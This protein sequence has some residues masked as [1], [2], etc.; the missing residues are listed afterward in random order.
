MAKAFSLHRK[1]I[2]H[3]DSMSEFLM[4]SGVSALAKHIKA[5]EFQ[6]IT[7]DRPRHELVASHLLWGETRGMDD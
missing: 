1:H 4:I 3:D 6:F 2:W 7:V 5:I